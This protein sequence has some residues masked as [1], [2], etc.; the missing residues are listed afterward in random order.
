MQ[1]ADKGYTNE[2]AMLYWEY[3]SRRNLA[4][5]GYRSSLEELD[6]FTADAFAI[7]EEEVQNKQSREIEK[8]RKKSSAGRR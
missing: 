8:S 5:L 4:K 2:A 7:I 3:I 6:C 1:G